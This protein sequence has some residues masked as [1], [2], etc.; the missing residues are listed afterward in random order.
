MKK[1][2]KGFIHGILIGIAFISAMGGGT[3]AVILGIYDDLVAAVSNLRK[4]FKN[5]IIYLT[6]ILLG[7]IVGIASLAYP[8]KL[9]LE[10]QPFIATSLFVGLTIGGLVVFKTLTKGHSSPLNFVFVLAG[11]MLVAA[12]G[13]IS[14]LSP[15]SSDSVA[16]T[17][18]FEQALILFT[19]GFFASSALIAPGI[20]GTMFLISLGY[21]NR[22]LDLIKNVLSFSG[23]NWGVNFALLMIFA[24]GF[25]IGFFAISKLM[26]Y[27]LKRFRIATYFV[28]LGL[29]IGQI[30]ISYFNGEIKLSYQEIPFSIWQVIFSALAIVIGV[31]AS[32]LLL[33]LANKKEVVKSLED[34]K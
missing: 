30:V 33:R 20:S 7:A 23:T 28:I 18:S 24:I 13:V 8:I 16:L 1:H 21:Y 3:L 19:I 17:L 26:D 6:P 4:D 29:I 2:L 25:V 31:I 9:F 5:S 34:T 32:L 11:F 10:W 14:W 27:L 12:I 15:S 22:L